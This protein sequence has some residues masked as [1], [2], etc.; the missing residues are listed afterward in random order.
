MEL[1]T[2]SWGLVLYT[3]LS[4]AFLI[5]LIYIVYRVISKYLKS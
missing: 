1:V 2:P 4:F 5:F 3:F